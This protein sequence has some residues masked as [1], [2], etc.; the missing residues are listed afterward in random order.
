MEKRKLDTTLALKEVEETLPSLTPSRP[1]TKCTSTARATGLPQ[2]PIVPFLRLTT[3]LSAEGKTTCLARTGDP[4]S[5][6]RLGGEDSSWRERVRLVNTGP[7]TDLQR[8][9]WGWGD[10]IG[11]GENVLFSPLAAG[12]GCLI[13]DIN[14]HS[15]KENREL[16]MKTGSRTRRRGGGQTRTQP[17]STSFSGQPCPNCRDTPQ[18]YRQYAVYDIEQQQQQQPLVA[19][20]VAVVVVQT[21]TVRSAG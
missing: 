3:I 9:A 20:A 2:A 21:F 4:C 5:A 15:A 17:I 13:L 16:N 19:I 12:R 10:D 6:R 11:A 1:A 14:K 8:R 18:L 7:E